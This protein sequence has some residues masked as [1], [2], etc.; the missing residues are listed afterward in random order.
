MKFK[1]L[2]GVLEKKVKSRQQLQIELDRILEKVHQK[3]I[4]SLTSKEKRILK[5]ATKTQQTQNR[6]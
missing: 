6:P 5:Q 3:G 2:T 4:H 1:I